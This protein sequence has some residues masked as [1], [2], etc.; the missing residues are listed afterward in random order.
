VQSSITLDPVPSLRTES[1]AGLEYRLTL[2]DQVA[3]WAYLACRS[4]EMLPERVRQRL[5]DTLALLQG[6]LG[7]LA[8]AGLSLLAWAVYPPA[9]GPCALVGFMAGLVL[10]GFLDALLTGRPGMFLEGSAARL[11]RWAFLRGLR[12][13]ARKD[14]AAGTLNTVT[15]YRLGLSAEGFTRSAEHRET[16]AGPL[17]VTTRV[18]TEEK[19]PWDAVAFVGRTDRHALLVV[20]DGTVVIVPRRCFRD[21]RAFHE[22]V[23]TARGHQRAGRGNF[24]VRTSHSLFG[25]RPS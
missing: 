13:L 23:E 5:K 17:T 20:T 1:P 21:D 6:I 9:V 25:S 8:M 24:H 4:P 12:D 19:A 3:S 7:V 18:A 2:E 11:Y 15:C 10:M 14:E 16:R 22:F